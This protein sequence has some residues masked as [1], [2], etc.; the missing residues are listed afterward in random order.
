ML[1]KISA[2]HL[3]SHEH[4]ETPVR[5]KNL[6][7]QCAVAV[8]PVYVLAVQLPVEAIGRK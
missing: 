4:A 8:R 1:V 5:E 3:L 2:E 7:L 6:I